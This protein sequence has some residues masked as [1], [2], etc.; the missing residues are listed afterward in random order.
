MNPQTA[1]APIEDVNR[2]GLSRKAI[3]QEV[4]AS[5]K[6]LETDYIGKC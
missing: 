5:L 2:G 6:R 3:M 1:E 4:D